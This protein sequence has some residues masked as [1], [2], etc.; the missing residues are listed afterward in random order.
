MASYI[1]RKLDVDFW[2]R[3]RTKALAEKI[4]VSD[5]ILRLLDEWLSRP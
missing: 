1:L 5:L 2:H 4:H 3:V